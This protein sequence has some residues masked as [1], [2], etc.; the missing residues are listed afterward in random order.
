M[1]SSITEI[2]SLQSNQGNYQSSY[3][4]NPKFK[5]NHRNLHKLR[6]DKRS[7]RN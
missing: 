7:I 5:I 4:T 3:R 1:T 2:S 6:I